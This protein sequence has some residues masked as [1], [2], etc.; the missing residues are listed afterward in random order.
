M[1]VNARNLGSAI[2]FWNLICAHIF[3]RRAHPAAS[4]PL[5]AS[6]ECH[7]CATGAGQ[8]GGN[9]ELATGNSIILRR[10]N[11][12]KSTVTHNINWSTSLRF[13]IP[14]SDLKSSSGSGSLRFAGTLALLSP[15]SVSSALDI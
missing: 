5:C 11:R 10:K 14:F 3:L 12:P 6:D 2:R 7:P 1:Y 13:N 8:V 4:G 15:L 9:L